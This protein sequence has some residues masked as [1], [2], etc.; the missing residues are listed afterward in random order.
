MGC[1]YLVYSSAAVI[2]HPDPTGPDAVLQRRHLL[3][4]CCRSH[5]DGETQRP[6]ERRR[7]AGGSKG[8]AE[9]GRHPAH[10]IPSPVHR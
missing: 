4:F 8:G 9:G 10:Q 2:L 6:L 3:L 7:W 1:F 5:R